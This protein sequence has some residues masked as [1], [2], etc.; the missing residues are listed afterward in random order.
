ILGPSSV[1]FPDNLGMVPVEATTGD[2][3]SVREC[4]VQ[5]AKRA[6]LA[7]FEII[8][9]HFAHGYLVSSFLSPHANHRTDRYGGS[10]ENRIRLALEIVQDVKAVLPEGYPVFVRISASDNAPEGWS[11]D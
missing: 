6:V 11:L 3:A 2:I 4:F 7:G 9:L 5:A 8:E 1:A 10:F